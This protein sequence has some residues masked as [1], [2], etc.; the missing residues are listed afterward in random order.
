MSPHV[1]TSCSDYAKL[2]LWCWMKNIFLR[3]QSRGRAD[4]A[5]WW[6]ESRGALSFFMTSEQLSNSSNC[7]YLSKQASI[8][9]LIVSTTIYCCDLT[10]TTDTWSY[11]TRW[12]TVIHC[13]LSCLLAVD[14]MKNINKWS[15]ILLIATHS[16]GNVGVII[17]G[18]RWC[19]RR[20]TD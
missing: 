10:I 3:C 17:P 14:D 18:T 7:S 12:Y 6:P 13:D 4:C 9:F 1:T 15:R 16:R 11:D 8:V 20:G 19:V 5:R 2:F